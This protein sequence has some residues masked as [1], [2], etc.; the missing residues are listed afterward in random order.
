MQPFYNAID[1]EKMQHT[2]EFLEQHALRE[3]KR[4]QRKAAADALAAEEAAKAA[5]AA[6]A[7]EDARLETSL[8]A[9][10]PQVG[11]DE[12]RRAHAAI[13]ARLSSQFGELRLAFRAFDQDGSGRVTHRRRKRRST[14]STW[15]CRGASR[16]PSWTLPISTGGDISFAEFARVL[17][18]D[19]IIFMKDSLEAGEGGAKV[20]SRMKGPSVAK[21][22][23]VIKDGVTDEDIRLLVTSLKEKTKEKYMRYD[24]AFKT[25]DEDRSGYLSREEFRFFI[26][27]MNL[28]NAFRK[29]TV[30]VLIDIMDADG[31]GKINHQEFV[32]MLEA[33]DPM[34]MGPLA[35]RAPVVRKPYQ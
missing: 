19:D 25:I 15:A 2:E 24:K 13:K 26:Y 27:M 12:L 30:E 29:E 6:K 14:R 23:K 31:D 33:E 18:A 20:N 32:R 7:A 9:G 11:D 4:A 8:R 34:N 35:S 21:M 1:Y 16:R 3:Q 22:P 28:Q 17:T 5:A 10:K